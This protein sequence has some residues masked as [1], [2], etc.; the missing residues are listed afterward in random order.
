MT[1]P[2]GDAA[3]SPY[4]WNKHLNNQQE[5]FYRRA[6]FWPACALHTELTAGL[7]MLFHNGSGVQ[8]NWKK[9]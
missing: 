1:L 3:F 5:G 8:V 7:E 4:T 9:T 6:N 2:P